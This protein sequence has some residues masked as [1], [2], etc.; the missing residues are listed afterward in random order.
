MK[1][2]YL[3][4]SAFIICV[5]FTAYIS[6]FFMYINSSTIICTLYS[7]SSISHKKQIKCVFYKKSPD[8][9]NIAQISTNFTLHVTVPMHVLFKIHGVLKIF[10]VKKRAKLRTSYLC[11][12]LKWPDQSFDNLPP[13]T[14]TNETHF[15][16]LQRY[17]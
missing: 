8:S 3:F 14:F 16:F 11:L 12:V 2:Y 17:F 4:L 5:R 1:F 6:Y 15:A 13:A 7:C 10:F 9:W